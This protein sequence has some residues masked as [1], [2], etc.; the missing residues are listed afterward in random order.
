MDEEWVSKD[1]P[2]WGK[3]T[4]QAVAAQEIKK[5]Y[6][7]WTQVR[8]TRPDAYAESGWTALTWYYIEFTVTEIISFHNAF[9]WLLST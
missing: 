9:G 3:P 2:D 7:W 5:L 8:P 4:N 6:L 1:D